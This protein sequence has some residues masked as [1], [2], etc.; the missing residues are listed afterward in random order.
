MDLKNIGLDCILCSSCSGFGVRWA[1]VNMAMDLLVL[2]KARTFLKDCSTW[3]Y[4]VWWSIV[5]SVRNALVLRSK[6]HFENLQK[7]YAIM[8]IFSFIASALH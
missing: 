3:R 1:V 6:K 7:F 2:Q 5:K 4:L 8:L